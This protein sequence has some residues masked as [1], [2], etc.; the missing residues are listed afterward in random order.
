LVPAESEFVSFE[1]VRE[2]TRTRP[3]TVIV[4]EAGRDAGMVRTANTDFVTAL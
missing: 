3:G 2:M 4:S 1:E